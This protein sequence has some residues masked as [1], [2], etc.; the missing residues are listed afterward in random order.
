MPVVKALPVQGRCKAVLELKRSAPALKGSRRSGAQRYITPNR[1]KKVAFGP[2][3]YVV[4]D[5]CSSLK[6][7]TITADGVSQVK[8]LLAL[9]SHV[10]ANRSDQGRFSVVPA[11]AAR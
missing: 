10:A 5:A 11:Y 7:S 3:K 2:K 8:A 1:P 6:N 9:R 4:A